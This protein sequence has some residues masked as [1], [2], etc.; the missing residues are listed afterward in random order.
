MS[1]TAAP[2]SNLDR[3]TAF[4]KGK[5]LTAAQIAGVEGNLQI[6]S[7]FSPTAYNPGEG[8]IGLA[9]WEKGR[10]ANLQSFAKEHGALAAILGTST[11]ADA[12]TAFDQKYERSAGTSR[13]KR[14]DAAA[15]I[16]AGGVVG[17][18]GQVNTGAGSAQPAGAFS[19]PGWLDGLGSLI[20]PGWGAVGTDPGGA[21]SGV[22]PSAIGATLG[23]WIVDGLLIIS[24]IVL[25][26][27]AIGIIAKSGESAG[28]S[29][30]PQP[31]TPAPAHPAHKARA[32]GATEDAAEV[33][34]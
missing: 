13:Q 20:V 3:I 16:F 2:A 4:L 1:T 21:L 15:N 27:V 18:S 8:A 9:Q 32:E 30:A 26:I 22:T 11:A 31:A 17:G 7:G 5:G 34:A 33:A 12:A 6:E 14:I 10:R 23:R 25:V 28:H 19:M 24:G 29:S